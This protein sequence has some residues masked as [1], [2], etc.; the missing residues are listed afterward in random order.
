MCRNNL[1]PRQAS[2]SSRHTHLLLL[3]SI[4]LASWKL[5]SAC[6]H[7]WTVDRSDYA[8]HGGGRGIWVSSHCGCWIHSLSPGEFVC[9]FCLRSCCQYPFHNTK[10]K[11][12]GDCLSVNIKPPWT[13][14]VTPDSQFSH[15]PPCA[16]GITCFPNRPLLSCYSR[17]VLHEMYS[18]RCM[19][20]KHS[21]NLCLWA[22]DKHILCLGEFSW[23]IFPA[24]IIM[25]FLNKHR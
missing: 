2:R 21:K 12:Q 5:S 4:P 20:L 19:L 25:S 9:L 6:P 10:K 18:P 3:Q 22:N 1:C 13:H 11:H 17:R 8:W 15:H 7:M 14:P 23:H 24:V 16:R